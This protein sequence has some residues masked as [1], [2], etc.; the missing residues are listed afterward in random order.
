MSGAA[1]VVEP[2]RTVRPFGR[3]RVGRPVGQ[4]PPLVNEDRLGGLQ[5]EP[6]VQSER[7]LLAEQSGGGLT[8]AGQ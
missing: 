8:S 2:G 6:V 3:G 4:G 5:L 7:D 1:G